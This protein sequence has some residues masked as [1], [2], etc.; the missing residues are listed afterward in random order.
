MLHALFLYLKNRI[1][2]SPNTVSTCKISRDSAKV[3]F[4]SSYIIS[5]NSNL[6]IIYPSPLGHA[7]YLPAATNKTKHR[8]YNWKEAGG[9]RICF[10]GNYPLQICVLDAPPDPVASFNHPAGKMPV[11]RMWVVGYFNKGVNVGFTANHT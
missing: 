6:D 3:N 2:K 9:S 4:F 8:S 10:P 1:N 11:V 7:F 5:S